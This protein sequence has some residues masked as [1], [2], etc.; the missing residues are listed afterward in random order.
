MNKIKMIL[1]VV[2]ITFGLGIIFSF[3]M[4]SNAKNI[5]ILTKN[6]IFDIINSVDDII[7]T[8]ISTDGEKNLSDQ[9]KLDATLLY[10]I[11][12]KDD[13]DI[14]ESN[15]S[16]LDL[17]QEKISIGKIN[18]KEFENELK[19]IFTSFRH[20]ISKYKYYDDGLINLVFEPCNYFTYDSKKLLYL[21]KKDNCY[22]VVYRYTRSLSD[23]ENN[24]NVKYVFN[25]RMK[26]KD[27][28]I[29]SSDIR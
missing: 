16:N 9:N 22:E 3:T 11:K 26:I 10:I 23:V 17:G 12:H 4:I 27:V 2:A 5:D 18:Q 19:N 8:C 6:T 29:L 25:D 24:I 13:F 28:I 14:K 20:D 15:L 21:L 7:I 1:F